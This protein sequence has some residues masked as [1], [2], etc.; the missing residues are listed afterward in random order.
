MT[1]MSDCNLMAK[2]LRAVKAPTGERL[3]LSVPD[4]VTFLTTAEAAIVLKRAPQTLR[5]WAMRGHP[6]NPVRIQG[7]LAWKVSD[8]ERLINGEV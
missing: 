5:I 8:L 2:E 1:F 3:K 4:G 7:R 6:I